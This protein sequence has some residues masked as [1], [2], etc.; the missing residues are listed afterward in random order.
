MTK[1]V[2]I[3]GGGGHGRV[4]A[5]ILRLQDTEVLG[6]TDPTP[7]GSGLELLGIRYLG[8]DGTI[9]GFSQD[10]IKLVNAIGSVGNTD[11]R[12]AVFNCFKEKGYSFATLVHPSAIVSSDTLQSEGL[13]VMAGAVVQAGTTIEANV[14]I[15]TR[16]TV[17]HDCRIG[18]HSHIASGAILSGGVTLGE[19]VHVGC[20]ATIIQGI[21]VHGRTVIGA[22]ALVLQ[23]VRV[24]CTVVGVPAKEVRK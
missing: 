9:D 6:Y 12:R 4:L 1:P 13:Q 17:D 22:G 8:D 5:D 2:I 18:A 3:V 7:S 11:K 15:N 14:L 23:S 19:G 24:E 21:H 10:Q 20:G 16:A